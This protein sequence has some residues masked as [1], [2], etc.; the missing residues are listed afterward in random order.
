M[1]GQKEVVRRAVREDSGKWGQTN[2]EVF[3]PSL[4]NGGKLSRRTSWP[5]P[6]QL[7]Q[8]GLADGL[9]VTSFNRQLCRLFESD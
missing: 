7:L 3:Y 4:P 1:Q 8:E 9:P 5:F 6:P 2:G